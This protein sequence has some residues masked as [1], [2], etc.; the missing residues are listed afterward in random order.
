MRAERKERD[1]TKRM[2]KDMKG[3]GGAEQGLVRELA[4]LLDETGLGEI[5]IEREGVRVR[6]ARQMTIAGAADRHAGAGHPMQAGRTGR[7]PRPQGGGRRSGQAS[8]RA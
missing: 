3:K 7:R 5:E 6:V 2:A 4:G 8:G 1:W